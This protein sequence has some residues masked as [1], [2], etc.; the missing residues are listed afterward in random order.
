MFTF[1]ESHYPIESHKW[2]SLWLT[3]GA[4]K[5]WHLKTQF[6]LFCQFGRF[7]PDFLGPP[8]KKADP[9]EDR[10]SDFCPSQ[11]YI[12]HWKKFGTN[13]EGSYITHCLTLIKTGSIFLSTEVFLENSKKWYNSPK[14]GRI[15]TIMVPPESLSQY[16]S[17][18]YQCYGVSIVS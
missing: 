3:S 17:N 2:K 10:K 4:Q 12:Y 9:I 11:T 1:S 16:L 7:D 6:W 15:S 5:Y 8:T 13:L 18:E 14:F